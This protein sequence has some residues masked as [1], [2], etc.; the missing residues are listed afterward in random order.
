MYLVS[1]QVPLTDKQL[2]ALDFNQWKQ[3]GEEFLMTSN[4]SNWVSCALKVGNLVK[5]LSGEVTCCLVKQV[6]SLCTGTLPYKLLI[7][8]KYGPA[9]STDRFYYCYDGSTASHWPTH[10]PCGKNQANQIKGVADPR[11]AIYIR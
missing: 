3:I 9:L 4:I 1:T 2:G 11:G 5:W 8:A 7:P 10:D 6:V